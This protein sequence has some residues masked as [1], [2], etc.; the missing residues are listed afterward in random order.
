MSELK[1]TKEKVIEAANKCNV[2]KETLKTLFPEVFEEEKTW[3]YGDIVE[4]KHHGKCIIVSIEYNRCYLIIINGDNKGIA[5][6]GVTKVNNQA[7]I[8]REE[9]ILMG[10]DPNKL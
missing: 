3:R 1:I 5:I 6:N 8:T 2:A 7:K 9:L 10:A 4:S